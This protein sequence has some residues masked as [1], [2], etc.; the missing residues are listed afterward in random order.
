MPKWV[1]QF[2][3]YKINHPKICPKTFN[4]L[5]QSAEISPNQA[6]LLPDNIFNSSSS[7]SCCCDFWANANYLN[8]LYSPLSLPRWLDKILSDGKFSFTCGSWTGWPDLAKFRHFD[9]ILKVLGKCLRVYLVFS[10]ILILLWQKWITIGQVFIV[11][12]GRML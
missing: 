1:Q 3:K 6:T 8:C 12:D 5:C 10:E 11:V 9:T 2:A 7:W 4:F